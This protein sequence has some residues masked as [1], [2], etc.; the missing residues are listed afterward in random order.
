MII[1][2]GNIQKWFFDY[3]EGNLTTLESK[4]LENFVLEH[5][6]FHE[7]FRAWKAS[8][9]KNDEKVPAFTPMSSLYAT[10]PFY[11]TVTFRVASAVALIFITFA[12]G[13]Y[14]SNV[15]DLIVQYR[16]TKLQEELIEKEQLN[17]YN[18]PSFY[19]GSSKKGKIEESVQFVSSVSNSEHS[20]TA[21]E[22]IGSEMFVS[23]TTTNQ[24]FANIGKLF[25][26]NDL[27]YHFN[28]KLSADQMI[29]P[30]AEF[31]NELDK[32]EKSLSEILNMK[33]KKYAFLD[34]KNKDGFGITNKKI[35]VSNSK[36]D[37]DN[38]ENLAAISERNLEGKTSHKRRKN[39]FQSLKYIELGLG[40]IN[41]PIFIS[42]N[43]NT[44]KINPALSG[45]LGITRVESI[46]RNQWTGSNAQSSYASL[47]ADG[48]FSKL[49]AGMSLGVNYLNGLNGSLENIE[50]NYSYVQKIKL[51]KNA[52]L[53]VGATYSLTSIN[54]SDNLLGTSHELTSS[55]YLNMNSYVAKSGKHI[56]NLGLSSW[57]SGKFFYGGFNVTNMLN[58]SLSGSQES[59][60][61]YFNGLE[62]TVQIGTD[63]RKNIY[64]H[65]VISPYVV[66]QKE[67]TKKENWGGVTLRHKAFIIGLSGSDNRSVKGM[68]GLQGNSLRLLYGYDLSKSD[69]NEK[70]L[71]SHEVSLRILFGNKTNNN[72]SRYGK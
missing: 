54:A 67:G 13:M 45:E 15:D 1:H 2:N 4:E 19:S 10:I 58:T 43:Y 35:K 21:E 44:V 11:E 8:S 68:V 64:A 38:E 57:Y 20:E 51:S 50:L 12:A 59:N 22:N 5:P 18:L 71:A 53:S 16:T 34:F 27:N 33:S 49:K 6:E 23:T 26:F 69:Y 9:E 42:P 66:M 63:Y 17:F 7:E 62:Y 46:Y 25:N 40:N 37:F 39:L 56:S 52:N 60:E 72:W 61:N 65:T 30:N 32:N 41:D 24:D 55:N 70:Y 29:E 3:V 48:Y 14:V 31:L 36:N 28:E 47:Y